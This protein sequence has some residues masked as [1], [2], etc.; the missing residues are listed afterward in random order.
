LQDLDAI[1][2]TANTSHVDS[3]V[4]SQ[5]EMERYLDGKEVL[6]AKLDIL[7]CW[8]F[9]EPQYPTVARMAK[10]IL[11]IP[12]AGVGVERVFNLGRDTCNYR[13]GHLHGETIKK[14]MIVK[15]AHQKDMVDEILL[16]EMELKKEA[17]DDD[18]E[19]SETEED[20]YIVGEEEKLAKSCHFDYQETAQAAAKKAAIEKARE[21]ARETDQRRLRVGERRSVRMSD[22]GGR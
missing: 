18:K 6:P 2:R 13:R 3:T 11:A 12:L 4:N 10:D 17:M 9:L 22:S 8:Q 16:S 20:N 1:L 19:S 21:T 5:N 7:E 15:H 14:I